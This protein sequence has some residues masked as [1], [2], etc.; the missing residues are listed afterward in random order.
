MKL[1]SSVAFRLVLVI[2]VSIALILGIAGA[3]MTVSARHSAEEQAR[4]N[5]AQLVS[6][7][8]ISVRAYNKELEMEA[9]KLS[10]VFG[11]LFDGR[12][13][14]VGSQSEK[15]A[16]QTVPVLLS[17]GE[18]ISGGYSQVDAFAEATGGN[19]TIFVRRGD[20]FV[21]VV[22]SV[23]TENGDRAIGTLLDRASPA[24]LPNLNG[25]AFNGK[26][27]LFGRRF[28]T[29]YTPIKD[30][31]GRVIGI[32]YVGIEFSESLQSIVDGL[33][34]QSIGQEGFIFLI[35]RGQGEDRGHLIS[36]PVAQGQAFS[37]LGNAAA[38]ALPTLLT[39]PRGSL[40]IELTVNGETQPWDIEFESIPELD[41]VVAATQPLSEIT[42]PASRLANR[43][44]MATGITLVLV[45]VVLILAVRRLVAKP[46]D[47]AVLALE[48]IAEGDYSKEVKVSHTGEI[49][50]LQDA[51]GTMQARVKTTIADIAQASF[52][53]ASAARQLT[54]A[55]DRMAHESR[56]QSE[57]ATAMASTIEELTANID[58][59]AG[60]AAEAREISETTNQNSEQGAEVIEAADRQMQHIADS[61][62]TAS[63]RMTALDEVSEEVA[64]IIEVIEN[65]AEQTNLLALNAAIEAA[66]AGEQGRG[67]AVVA[68][69]V[70]KLASRT[71]ESA[72][73]ITTMIE[74]MRNG[75]REAVNVMRKNL[76]DVD[77]VAR[78]GHQ[79]GDSIKDIQTAAKRVV[80]VFSEISDRLREQATANNEVAQNVESI[81]SMAETNDKSAQEVAQATVE[82]ESMA[83]RLREVVGRFRV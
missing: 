77:T 25:K 22:T 68:D 67:F 4:V 79:A 45:G 40:S 35:S 39:E 21:R 18:P 26:V 24:Y 76:E 13:E 19:A 7:A 23:K 5:L 10:A 16:G 62:R 73:E 71:T 63:D 58:H 44:M 12:F 48:T 50:R 34:Q 43:L 51:L 80:T 42:L 46:L 28:V 36:H 55:G 61:V 57:A 6:S 1:P 54:E 17:N 60:N 52:E 33:A 38:A 9:V 66:R 20:D 59:L 81:A 2:G 75:T 14:L 8:A 47:D 29:N 53:L 69:E 83:A 11:R 32:R 82:L 30:A 41:W 37:R 49:G 74:K 56:H 65:I 64:T 72:H 78:L 15:V 31:G 70:R 3:F 27:T